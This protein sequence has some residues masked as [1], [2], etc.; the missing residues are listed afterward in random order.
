MSL[1]DLTYPEENA[2]D[3]IWTVADGW[4][5]DGCGQVPQEE[6]QPAR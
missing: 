1:N 4:T 5:T 6:R 2:D 3:N